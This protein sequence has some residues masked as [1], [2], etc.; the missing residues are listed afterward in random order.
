MIA[1][2]VLSMLG[3]G[4]SSLRADTP[5]PTTKPHDSFMVRHLE[6]IGVT[7]TAD[8]ITKID[9]I[10]KAKRAAA[11]A[12]LTADQQKI[13]AD[14]KGKGHAAEHAAWQ[15]VRKTLTEGQKTKLQELHK[16]T[17]LEV[18]A[19]LTPEQLAKVEAFHKEHH[20]GTSQPVP[21][22]APAT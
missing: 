21:V 12:V 22:P 11:E 20:K 5:A 8:Q 9:C 16:A 15:E 1:T 13:L 2:A 6:R 18:K 3:M 7:L 4:I 19:V 17:W 14:A 10:E